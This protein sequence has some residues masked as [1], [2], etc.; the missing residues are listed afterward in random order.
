MASTSTANWKDKVELQGND[1]RSIK[2]EEI[3]KRKM[4]NSFVVIIIAS[5]ILATTASYV[6]VYTH[7]HNN[8][9]FTIQF[10]NPRSSIV[11]WTSCS[12]GDEMFCAYSEGL[13]TIFAT[14]DSLRTAQNQSEFET[15]LT[16]I[17]ATNTVIVYNAAN[18]TL[19]TPST[20]GYPFGDRDKVVKLTT[21]YGN[22]ICEDVSK[23][24]TA[25]ARLIT[26]VCRGWIYVSG[27][28]QDIT[29]ETAPLSVDDQ[30]GGYAILMGRMLNFNE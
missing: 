4:N 30:K 2:N 3:A 6:Y 20:T 5:L 9:P 7:N 18:N 23:N 21:N 27:A 17:S 26:A 25:P 22:K 16:D 1:V 10:M 15:I 11:T 13:S 29:K 8:N 28:E 14:S 12:E 24:Y 19:L